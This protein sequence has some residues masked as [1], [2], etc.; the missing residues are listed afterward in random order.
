MTLRPVPLGRAPGT[1]WSGG[2]VVGWSLEQVRM[3]CGLHS[4]AVGGLQTVT[5][6]LKVT[7]R[8]LGYV[9]IVLQDL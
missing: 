7:L 4:V 8:R 5:G 1:R 3:L 6:G 2:W 9:T